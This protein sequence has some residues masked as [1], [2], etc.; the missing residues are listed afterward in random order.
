MLIVAPVVVIQAPGD[1]QDSAGAPLSFPT[2]PH[3]HHYHTTTT[4]TTTTEPMHLLTCS[5]KHVIVQP[6]FTGPGWS[7]RQ[8]QR[9]ARHSAPWTPASSTSA[10]P[11]QRSR[12]FTNPRCD[13]GM[14]CCNDAEASTGAL[15]LDPRGEARQRASE[16]G[17]RPNEL[18]SGRTS[19]TEENEE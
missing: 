5:P 4:T 11:L 14:W 19:T 6:C 2:L 9:T 8:C 12:S 15:T 10:S 7:P 16:D 1:L 3:H 13:G 17:L 18:C